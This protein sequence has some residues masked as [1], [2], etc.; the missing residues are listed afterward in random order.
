MQSALGVG[1]TFSFSIP[2]PPS[3]ATRVDESDAA[4]AVIGA[5]ERGGRVLVVED[6]RRSADLFGC[7]WRASD[8]PYA[9]A[10]D[11]VEGLEWRA[12]SARGQ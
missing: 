10:R 4:S 7:T 8:T 9:V 5:L 2:L 6:D 3:S 12:S 1:S 11:G